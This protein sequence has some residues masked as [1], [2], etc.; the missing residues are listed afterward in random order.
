MATAVPSASISSAEYDFLIQE[1][2]R[3]HFESIKNLIGINGSLISADRWSDQ[4]QLLRWI[5]ICEQQ[6]I[7]V[8]LDE[9][10][11]L[12]FSSPFKE[13]ETLPVT[14]LRAGHG[15]SVTPLDVLSFFGYRQLLNGEINPALKDPILSELTY[16]AFD[17]HLIVKK[18]YDY[19]DG[20]GI[21]IL[22]YGLAGGIVYRYRVS[23]RGF[24]ELQVFP[25]FFISELIPEIFVFE[26][27][28]AGAARITT[29]HVDQVMLGS[30]G[31]DAITIEKVAADI[32]R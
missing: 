22:E 16:E 6:E 32:S 20:S 5:K 8:N 11:L 29:E 21:E 2:D 30:L 4:Y 26:A 25:K 13:L 3:Q 18:K 15:R 1:K 28:R 19:L 9:S 12:E 31:I 14:V 17:R 7:F 23:T 10:H 24:R 27:A